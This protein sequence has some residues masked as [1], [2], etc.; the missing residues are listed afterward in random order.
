[1]IPAQAAPDEANVM[2]QALAGM[3]WSKQ[4]YVYDVYSWMRG[5]AGSSAQVKSGERL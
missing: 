2:R 1:V 3:L 4:H 5:A